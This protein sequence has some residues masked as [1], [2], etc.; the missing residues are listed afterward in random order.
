MPMY[1]HKPTVT[2]A[3]RYD[4]PGT[5]SPEFAAA[6]CQP[7]CPSGG[8]RYLNGQPLPHIDTRH[9]PVQLEDGWW[10]VAELDGEGYYPV[11][12]DV[13]AASYEACEDQS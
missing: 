5:L 2:E 4:G 1:V 13:F 11:A 8:F 6:I 3:E 12:P 9:G 7:P 10:V